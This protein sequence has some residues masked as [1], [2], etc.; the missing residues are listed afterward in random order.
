MPE[1][2]I[3]ANPHFTIQ[4][5]DKQHIA[6]QNATSHLAP[7]AIEAVGVVVQS[8]YGGEDHFIGRTP[9]GE[10]R[11]IVTKNKDGASINET[12]GS[13]VDP[14]SAL[15]SALEGTR[16][17]ESVQT[18]PLVRIKMKE[19]A[20]VDFTE[21]GHYSPKIAPSREAYPVPD[22]L[23]GAITD[24]PYGIKTYSETVTKDS[25]D[26]QLT[27]IVS[28]YLTNGENG[29]QLRRDLR[30]TDLRALTPEQ[31]VKL[32][33]SV[34][35]NLSKYSRDEHGNPDGKRA[36]GLTAMQLLQEGIASRGDPNWQGNGV[37]RNI[38]SNTKA[39][40]EALKMNQGE[41]SMLRNTYAVF[42]TG[43]DGEGYDNSREDV[44]E[45]F[46]T[47][48]LDP[49]VRPGHA[50]IKFITIDGKGS[51][52]IAIVDPTWALERDA[53]IALQHMDY[54]LPRMAKLAGD[55][56][57]GSKY[58]KEAF[59]EISY[60]YDKLMQKALIDKTGPEKRARI[61]DFAMTEYLKAAELVLPE[62][63]EGNSFPNIPNG[64][65]AAAYQ[66]K[67]KLQ[68]N[69]LETL[70]KIAQVTPL[71]NFQAILGSYVRG[72]TVQRPGWQR[73]ERLVKPNDGLQR[74]IL[75]VLNANEI[76]EFADKSGKF[77]ARL[78]GLKPDSLPLFDASTREADAKELSFLAEQQNI[79]TRNP[80]HIVREVRR[81][82][83]KEARDDSLFEAVTFGRSDYDLVKNY[84][85][86]R[87]R[88]G[89]IAK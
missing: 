7:H 1:S 68:D 67:D 57:A 43:Y 51:T 63:R 21:L 31:A 78:R 33:L 10:Y 55:L 36:D 28:D 81:R 79:N 87:E 27:E 17:L 30:I 42:D 37:C 56:F 88:I 2:I 72:T 46:R 22:Y 47:F 76:A 86:L 50:W 25:W 73:I 34:V 9:E 4:D 85:D 45:K 48:S 61:R 65:T 44:D 82:L 77:R 23:E 11:S 52:N 19:D 84:T 20:A 70:Y 13:G 5:Q 71:E 35:Q 41:H 6:Q 60:Y 32:S 80:S 66:L 8:F 54:T 38:A 15:E 18:R 74:E 24:S 75:S 58:K 29:Q 83:R 89:K 14:S 62:F 64:V 69:E 16:S 3:E 40:F 49:K 12:A 59:D 26:K 53:P 39:V